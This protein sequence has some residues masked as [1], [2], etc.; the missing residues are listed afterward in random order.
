[1]LECS[2]CNRLFDDRFRVFAPPY[3][4]PF[5]RIECARRAG[6]AQGADEHMAPILLPTVEALRPRAEPIRRHSESLPALAGRRLSIAALAFSSLLPAQA[7]LASGAALLT[8][9]TA[10]SVYLAAKPAPRAPAPKP[11]VRMQTS[12]TSRGTSPQFRARPVV[13][14]PPAAVVWQ[15]RTSPERAPAPHHAGRGKFGRQLPTAVRRDAG[16]AQLPMRPVP[17]ELAGPQRPTHSSTEPQAATPAA[18]PRPEAKSEPK[19]KP[20]DTQKPK[21][22]P[23]PKGTQKPTDTHKPKDN[24]QPKD[25]QKPKHTQ[26]PKDNATDTS[27]PKPATTK[28]PTAEAPAPAEPPTATPPT[29]SESPTD[30]ARDKQP[31]PPDQNDNHGGGKG[32]GNNG[33]NGK[34]GGH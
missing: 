19:Q 8:G 23:K 26:K 4:E 20:T 31:G 18:E 24:Q 6:A 3:P 21:D 33:R 9:G 28:P 1:M 7:A 32:D 34:G 12:S 10:A 25:T 29:T 22:T 11:A 27:K 5:D 17:G 16:I 14:S 15:E 2:I 30:A 13:T